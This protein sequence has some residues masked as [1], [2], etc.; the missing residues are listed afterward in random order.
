MTEDG[1]RL[2]RNQKRL[3][4]VFSLVLIIMVLGPTMNASAKQELTPSF[5]A[6]GGYEEEQVSTNSG[7]ATYVLENRDKVMTADDYSYTIGLD[8]NYLN[9]RS[10]MDLTA[11]WG[12]GW[13][14]YR[15]RS[16]ENTNPAQGSFSMSYDYSPRTDISVSDNFVF[17]RQSEEIDETGMQTRRVDTFR[18]TFSS[19][20]SHSLSQKTNLDADYGF[21]YTRY[22]STDL[23]DNIVNDISGSW[24]YSV[25]RRDGVSM[26]AGY[27]R[28]DFPKSPDTNSFSAGIGWDHSISPVYDFD[29]RIGGT[30]SYEQGNRNDAQTGV[31][32]NA[33]IRRGFERG[34]TSLT[35][36]QDQDTSGGTGEVVDKQTGKLSLAYKLS[37]NLSSAISGSVAMY[38]STFRTEE[39]S[40]EALIDEEVYNATVSG[41]YSFQRWVKVSAG[42]SYRSVVDMNPSGSD[43]QKYRIYMQVSIGVPLEIIEGVPRLP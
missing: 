7:E 8:F 30:Y 5:R 27:S 42:Y 40:E 24:I 41:S 43:L 15:D 19:G 17:D 32:A 23:E 25:S 38:D 3:S 35:Y 11:H 28:F 26:D 39:R 6:R 2:E 4:I 14:F 31:Y 13:K 16:S 33:S 34:S 18:N 20:I 36:S 22:N 12:I 21:R 37:E 29:L 10:R 1:T 9:N